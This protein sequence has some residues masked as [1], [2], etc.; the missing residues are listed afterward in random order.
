[1]VKEQEK[2]SW[3]NGD[4]LSSI[5]HAL[6]GIY[7][8]LNH[9]YNARLIFLFAI[10][11]VALGFYLEISNLELFVLGVAIMI[12]F[13]AEVINTIVEDLSNLIT[14]EFNP[15]IKIIKDV[16]AG[17]VLVAIFFSAALGYCVFMK[18]IIALWKW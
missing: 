5:K 9:H 17:V 7:H 1:M 2:K 4:L 12:V 13:I 16:T 18:R 8:I 3:K 11:A 10:F 15:K 6:Y 14:K